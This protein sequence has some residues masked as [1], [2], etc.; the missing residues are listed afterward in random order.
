MFLD[1]S[2]ETLNYSVQVPILRAMGLFS[3]VSVDWY[4]YDYINNVDVYPLK[5]SLTFGPGDF[6][7]LV[8]IWSQRDNVSSFNSHVINM[9]SLID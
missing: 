9:S 1:E 6:K 2:N 5:G 4:I 8:Q 3:T 7:K